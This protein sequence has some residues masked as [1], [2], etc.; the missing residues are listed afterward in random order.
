MMMF[1][2]LLF[3][4]FFTSGYEQKPINYDFE[5]QLVCEENIQPDCYCILIYDPV[6]GC[7]NKT[8]G[9]SCQAMCSGITEYKKGECKEKKPKKDP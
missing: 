4:A 8:Y 9:N 3:T 7:N 5:S 2:V 1:V 6:C